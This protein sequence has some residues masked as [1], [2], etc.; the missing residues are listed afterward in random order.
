L[1]VAMN[2]VFWILVCA[3]LAA[4]AAMLVAGLRSP[5]ESGGRE[6]G[7]AFG[8]L[9]PAVVVV[10]AAAVYAKANSSIARNVAMVVAAAPALILIVVW[11]RGYLLDSA[12]ANAGVNAFHDPGQRVLAKAIAGNKVSKVKELASRTK[13]NEPGT[14]EL[15]GSDSTLL[16][17]ALT[18]Q[19]AV[20]IEIVRVLL[21][22]G[23]NPNQASEKGWTIPLVRA[24]QWKQPELVASFLDAGADPNEQ[25]PNGGVAYYVAVDS[26]DDSSLAIFE[27]L[28]V[29]GANLEAV[30]KSGKTALMLT[31]ISGNWKAMDMLLK[32]GTRRDAKDEKGK[33]A[34]DFAQDK[35]AEAERSTQTVDPG[36]RAMMERLR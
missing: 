15:T 33:T 23:A 28:L 12:V 21:K 14:N 30:D 36:M 6:M 4:L 31:A 5:S 9:L 7:L 32:R 20:T 18:K 25:D 26:T 1:A 35:I 27:M 22:A 29:H 11:V 2:K 10:S 19:T 3:E 17:L 24:I 13:L 34:L 8:V 16:T